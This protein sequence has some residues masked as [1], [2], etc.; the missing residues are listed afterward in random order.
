MH[1]LIEL[2]H[3]TCLALEKYE[4]NCQIFCDISKAFDRVWH[5]ISQY[6]R[7]VMR[8]PAVGICEIKGTD[9]LHSNCTAEQRLCFRFIDSTNPLLYKAKA[10]ICGFTAQ[11]VS[12]L[13]GNSKDRFSRD[14]PHIVYMCLP[15]LETFSI[16]SPGARCCV[17][18]QDTS[19]SLLCASSNQ[20]KVQMP[21]KLLTGTYD[22]NPNKHS[23]QSSF[24]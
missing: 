23:F 4:M 5:R 8:K 22:F 14:I 16:I 17:I 9:Q 12:D 10:I 3:N 7:R 2:V 24:Q 1:H 13:V 21:E 11:F 18:E 15:K 19:S 20:E 6:M